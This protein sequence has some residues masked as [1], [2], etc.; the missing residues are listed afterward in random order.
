MVR[1]LLFHRRHGTGGLSTSTRTAARRIDTFVEE[2]A[3]PVPVLP[4]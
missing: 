4:R 3:R 2:F 1:D